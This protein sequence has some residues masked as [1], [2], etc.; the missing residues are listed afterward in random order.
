M[1]NKD[2]DIDARVKNA[3][4]GLPILKPDEQNRCLGTFYERIEL[5]ITFSE[6]MR[7]DWTTILEKVMKK[8]RNYQLLFN[9]R[10][11]MEILGQYIR[12]ANRCAMPFAIKN[13]QHYRHNAESAAIILCA[14]HALNRKEIDIMKRYPQ[15]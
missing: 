6:A 10:L 11:D 14:D 13:S 1:Q 4:L 12:L 9:G 15:Y 5:K 7:Y 3:V 2:L 8:K